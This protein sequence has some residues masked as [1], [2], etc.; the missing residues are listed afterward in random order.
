MSSQERQLLCLSP[1]VAPSSTGWQA[2]PAFKATSVPTGHLEAS[3]ESLCWE[4]HFPSS[5]HAFLHS[6]SPPPPLCLPGI[7]T[8]SHFLRK[9]WYCNSPH[10]GT[11]VGL[12]QHFTCLISCYPTPSHRFQEYTHF[13][14]EETEAQGGQGT[15]TPE[16]ETQAWF[17][18]LYPGLPEF[19]IWVTHLVH[20]SW[21]QVTEG[22]QRLNLLPKGR[23]LH[24]EYIQRDWSLIS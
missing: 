5:S 3:L 23:S 21:L 12:T 22:C 18:S 14:A 10:H 4:E 13:R 7:L 1:V 11:G 17:Q 6:P 8:H 19:P 24:F 20:K 9:S 2:C 16:G 15:C